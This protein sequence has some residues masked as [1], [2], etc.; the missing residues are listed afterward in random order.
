MSVLSIQVNF[1]TLH[2]LIVVAFIVFLPFTYASDSIKVVGPQ[3]AQDAS[4]DYFVS[5]LRMALAKSN[6]TSAITIIP[7][8][9]QGRVLK[10]LANSD[11]YDVVWTGVSK[12]RDQ[13]LH[14]VPIPLFKGGLGWR[15]LVMRKDAVDNFKAISDTTLLSKYI[16]CQGRHW[17]DADIL[18]EAGLPVQ[19]VSSFDAMLEMVELRRCDYLPLSIFEGRSELA[20]VQDRFPTLIFNE[21]LI[22]SYPITMNFYVKK[23]NVALA[24]DLEA[25]LIKLINSGEFENFMKAHSLTKNGFPIERLS[26]A[27]K[28]EL[29]NHDISQ[30]T[31]NEL[32][33]YGFKWLQQKPKLGVTH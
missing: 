8:S 20:A 17:P 6:N 33:S 9:G 7:H 32:A 28:I 15:G 24:G 30:E 1:Y 19:L 22:I 11:L 14:R 29:Q 2:I 3:K 25:G 13:L 31:L 27:T 4:H 16:A 10:M 18:K 23:N 26:K 5:L 12:E 21:S